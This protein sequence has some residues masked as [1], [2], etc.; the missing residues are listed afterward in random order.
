[1]SSSNPFRLVLALTL[2][3]PAACAPQVGDNYKGE[4]LASL[5]GVVLNQ[6]DRS[7]GP[8]EAVL[9]WS[10]PSSD[11]DTTTGD[12]VPVAGGFPASFRLDI[13]QPPEEAALNDL[14]VGGMYPDESRI[15]LAYITALPVG[16][17]LTGAETEPYGMSESHLLLYLESDLQTGTSG[18]ALVGGTLEAGFH[19]LEVIDFDDPAC[20]EEFN[21]CLRPAP[22]GLDT[23]V[24]LR[25][26][27]AE[28]I[29]VPNWG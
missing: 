7:V 6:L 24:E 28:L 22:G 21:D 5:R 20:P 25:I 17:D 4:P 1:M 2:T 29:D 13:Y 14:T 16:Y 19:L 9:V 26:D 23:E 27:K 10:N 8:L 3:I 12:R 18:E 15:G 11:P